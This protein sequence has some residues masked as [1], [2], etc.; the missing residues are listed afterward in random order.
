LLSSSL[1]IK[2]FK[3]REIVRRPWLLATAISNALGSFEKLMVGPD[4]EISRR[5]L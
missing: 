5:L 2:L 1:G 3:D 4:I